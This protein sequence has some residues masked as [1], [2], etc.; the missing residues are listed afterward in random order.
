M[1]FIDY[2][3]KTY[4]NGLEGIVLINFFYTQNEVVKIILK[5]VQTKILK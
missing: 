3:G 5:I 4:P 2:D 1:L